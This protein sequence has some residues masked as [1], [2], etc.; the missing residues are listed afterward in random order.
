MEAALQGVGL[1]TA[2]DDNPK[3]L[4]FARRHAAEAGAS[5]TFLHGRLEE[6]FGSRDAM[7]VSCLTCNPL[8]RLTQHHKHYSLIATI[9]LI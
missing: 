9:F 3:M 1:V 5:V 2:V 7:P 8:K 6:L 4:E